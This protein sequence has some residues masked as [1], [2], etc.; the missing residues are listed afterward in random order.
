MLVLLLG[1]AAQAG[2]S[3]DSIVRLTTNPAHQYTGYGRQRSIALDRAGNVHVGWLDERTTPHQIWYRRY[4]AA[5]GAWLPEMAVTD[6]PVNCRLPSLAADSSGNLHLAWHVES[7]PDYGIWYKRRDALSQTWSPD[8]LIDSGSGTRFKLYPS[9]AAAGNRVHVAWSGHPDTGMF[10]Q[11]FHKEFRPDSGWMET[12][13]IT[14]APGMHEQVSVAADRNGDVLVA[15][16]GKDFGDP[17]TQ[18]YCRRR[19]GGAWC[20]VELVSDMA[21]SFAQFSPSAAAGADGFHVAWHGS[22]GT[23][24]YRRVYHRLRRADAWTDIKTVTGQSERQQEYASAAVLPN[25]E[26]HLLWAGQTGASNVTQLWHAQRSPTGHWAAPQKLTSRTSNVRHPAIAAG[27]DTTAHVAWHDE[28]SGN[29]DVYYLRGR[30]ALV[31]LSGPE[32]GPLRSSLRV[33]PNPCAA[34]VVTLRLE[35]RDKGVEGQRDRVASLR[36]FDAAG[37]C[38]LEQPIADRQSPIALGLRGLRGGVYFIR[39]DK[40]GQTQSA[41]LIIKE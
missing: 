2:P 14:A 23:D 39:V 32:R 38:V 9:V 24:V 5:Q 19:V 37:R 41:K 16:C 35:A 15:W 30:A 10:Y 27:S 12:E 8:T 25:G 13:M 18:V 1:A 33:F 28:T 21:S 40:A 4:D 31:G 3:W 29:N 7:W 11:A 6:R 17:F 22:S 20:E 26:C 36:L 34:G